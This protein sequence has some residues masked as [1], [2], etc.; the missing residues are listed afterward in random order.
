MASCESQFELQVWHDSTGHEQYSDL[1]I[2]F[3]VKCYI[4]VE[5]LL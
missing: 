2:C 5:D 1:E 3:I 4:T